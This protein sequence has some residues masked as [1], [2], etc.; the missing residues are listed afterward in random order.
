VQAG[1]GVSELRIDYGPGYRVYFVLRWY[2][3]IILLAG[4]CL[5]ENDPALLT[6]A[7]GDIARARGMAQ[8]PRDTGLTRE[9][10]YKASL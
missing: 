1:K 9:G 5:E 8:V 6:A 3:L 4:A 2:E 10:L 7:L